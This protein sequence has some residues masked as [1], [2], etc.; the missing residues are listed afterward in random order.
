MTT[1]YIDLTP[2]ASDAEPTERE[3]EEYEAAVAKETFSK[4]DRRFC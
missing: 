3:W 1:K 2:F 4:E